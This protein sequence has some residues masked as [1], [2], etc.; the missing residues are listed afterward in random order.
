MEEEWGTLMFFAKTKDEAGD[1]KEGEILAI[2]GSRRGRRGAELK[3][4]SAVEHK[5]P[6]YFLDG[7]NLRDKLDQPG[8]NEGDAFD[9]DT[10]PFQGDEF[11]YA[12]G[13]R[14]TTRKKLAAAAGCI[15]EYIGQ[16]AVIAGGKRERRQG[17]DYLEWLLKQ[18]QGHLYADIKGR[19]DVLEIEAPRS[20]I[21][22]VTGHKGEGLHDDEDGKSPKPEAMS[23][24]DN[25]DR[26][27]SRSPLRSPEDERRTRKSKSRSPV[28]SPE[29]DRRK[30][31]ASRSRSRS[32]GGKRG[33]KS[34]SRSRSP[35]ADRSRSPAR[36]EATATE[37]MT[38]GDAD[39]AF[40]LGRGGSTKMKIARVSGA[41]LDLQD[42]DGRLD[43]FGTSLARSRA[44]D[45]VGYV[46]TQRTGPVFINT[47]DKRDDLSIVNVPEDC[48][49]YVMGRG[50]TVLRSMEEEWGTLMF[51]AKTKDEAG[52]A[53]EG[54]ILAIFGSRRG[55]RGAE[56]KV[57][58]AV[59][60]KHPGY[61]LD[62]DNLRDKLDQPGDNEGDAF[63]YDTFPFQGDEFSYALGARGTT[64]KKLAAAAGCILEYIGQVAVIAGGKRERRQ[65]RDYLEWLLKQ[66]QG[67]LYADIKGRDDV[68]EIEAPRSS[69]GYVTGHKGEGLRGIEAETRTFC[70]TNAPKEGGEVSGSTETILVFGDDEDDRRRAKRI[71]EDRIEQSQRNAAAVDVAD[72]ATG[73]TTAAGD[74]R[75]IAAAMAAAAAVDARPRAAAA[76]RG[77]ISATISRRAVATVRRASSVTTTVAAAAVVTVVDT[78]AAVVMIATALPAE[79]IAATIATTIAATI[80]ATTG[81]MTAEMTAETT[82]DM[83]A[84]ADGA[85]TAANVTADDTN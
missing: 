52:D 83:A 62:G 55:R 2:F 74:A 81:V 19:D 77:R 38:V 48:V 15:L 22:Y 11:S 60:H 24:D 4:M 21:G 29:D 35:M 8:D 46:L 54:E 79:T 36:D 80:A 9:Y 26:R 39:A 42:R 32:G 16:V 5:H 25:E 58:S 40:V 69:I 10:F 85:T 63:D 78:G 3:V 13:A 7:D 68:L 30:K 47:T 44:K 1:A 76:V 18:R 27:R 49:G 64:R 17:R 53:K 65:G 75:L 57:M 70:F 71:I 82:G 41:R 56:L 23:D 73:T 28:R 31:I 37:S 20:S 66:R 43:I 50:G 51:F 59:E 12:L 61:F 34:R 14:G 45:Y 72:Q 6:G 33:A 67:H 84:A